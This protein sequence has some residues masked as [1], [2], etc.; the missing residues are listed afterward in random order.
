MHTVS[1]VTCALSVFDSRLNFVITIRDVRI[2]CGDLIRSVPSLS[3]GDCFIS[4][5]ALRCG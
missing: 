2:L 3:T 4:V 5:T 1:S